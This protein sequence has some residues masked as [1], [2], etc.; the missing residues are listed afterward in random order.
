MLNPCLLS[1]SGLGSMHT[2]G[3]HFPISSNLIRKNKSHMVNLSPGKTVSVR[4]GLLYSN[5]FL[6]H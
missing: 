1:Q 2:N 4:L 6:Q 5:N 3:L